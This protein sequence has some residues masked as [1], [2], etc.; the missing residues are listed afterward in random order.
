M[1]T[2]FSPERQELARTAW[3]GPVLFVSEGNAEPS[4]LRRTTPG[5]SF[6]SFSTESSGFASDSVDE[7][8]GQK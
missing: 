5:S 6:R 2:Y 8:T 1:K 3:G 4:M 7:S